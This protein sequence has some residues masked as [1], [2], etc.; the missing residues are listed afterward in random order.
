M[1]K[2]N[3]AFKMNCFLSFK[4]WIFSLFLLV[5]LVQSGRGGTVKVQADSILQ[6][7]VAQIN[8]LSMLV[9]GLSYGN[10]SSYLGRYQAKRLPYYTA[11]VSYMHKSGWWISGLAYQVLN[12]SSFIDEVDVMGGYNFDFTKKID[13]SIYYS[14]YFFSPESELIKAS[15]A[16]AMNAS[17]GFDWSYVYSRLSGSFIFGESSDFFLTFDNSRYFETNQL[18]HKN[19]YLSFEPKLSV[20]AGTQTFVESHISRAGVGMYPIGSGP[21]KPSTGGGAP[22][23]IGGGGDSNPLN[24]STTSLFNVLNYEISLPVSYTISNLSFEVAG[25]YSIPVNL[26]EGDESVPRLFLTTSLFYVIN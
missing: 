7:S 26:L 23:S 5:M 22:S 3:L 16:N 17:I 4:R 25:R 15:V 13:G 1:F 11:D 6:D 10:N 12:S 9:L 21:G 2:K 24:E 14:R 20:I 19:D 8:K 18:L